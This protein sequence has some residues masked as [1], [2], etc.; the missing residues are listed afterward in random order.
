MLASADPLKRIREQLRAPVAD[1]GIVSRL[2]YRAQRDLSLLREHKTI[3]QVRHKPRTRISQLQQ[4]QHAQP[5]SPSAIKARFRFQPHGRGPVA[6]S[7]GAPR[8]QQQ[9]KEEKD[10]PKHRQTKMKEVREKREMRRLKKLKQKAPPHCHIWHNP[11]SEEVAKIP[12]QFP[13]NT[14]QDSL[15]DIVSFSAG[16]HH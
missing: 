16:A 10:D 7:S 15:R 9:E 4:Q 2:S 8:A 14:L 13:G 3:K 1:Q 5:D 12:M 11:N 6:A